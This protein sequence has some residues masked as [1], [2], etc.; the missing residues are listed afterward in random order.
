MTPKK[1][2]EFRIHRFDP[3]QE[4]HYLS[5]YEVP[6]R[7]GTTILDAL[8]Y[9]KDNLDGTLTFRHQCRMGQCGSCGV[10]VNGKPMLACYKQ[11][12]Q[13]ETDTL[14][15]EPL[16]NLPVIKDLAVDVDPFFQKFSEINPLLI[17]D[18]EE[19]QRPT[20]FIQ[21]PSDL[22]KYWDESICTKCSL[23]YA[24]CPAAI[25]LR[26]LGP[27]TLTN[28]YRFM[29]D[30]RDEGAKERIEDASE[31]I[32][33]C[34]SCDS[35]T[36]SCPKEIDCALALDE[37]RSLI[38]EDGML[39]P[40][41][42][43]EVLTSTFK[44][45]NPVRMPPGKR[46]DWGQ[47]LEIKQLPQVGE[48]DILYFVGCLPSYDERNQQIARSMAQIFRRLDEE[49][50]T[51][52]TEEWCCGDHI[53]R[54]GEK[55]L[56]EELA[57]H[58]LSVFREY[59]FHRLVTLSPHCYHT[60]K[61]DRPYTD[62][63]MEVQHYTQFLVEA[64]QKGSIESAKAIEK[65]VTYHDP[66]FLGKRSEIYEQPR[67]ILRW[68][69]GLELVEMGR[70]RENSFCCGGGA[71][72]V[73]TEE[74]TPQD[75]PAVDRAEEALNLGVDIIATACPFCITTLEDAVKVLDAEY[76]IMVRDL[77]ELLCEAI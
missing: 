9:I 53:L 4:K 43:K 70:S 30:T 16:P 51:L 45:H 50:A 13:L 25:D 69:P 17:K 59:N 35:C 38:V 36:L 58:N 68:I 29:V 41:T 37:E 19:L 26:F 11:V 71:G 2:V 6:V 31:T 56:F 77:S 76:K 73:W 62:L 20:E 23:C 74:A 49:F 34:T 15:V 72:R 55:G 27:A 54:L 39:V 8:R 75:R 52:G 22:K 66:C 40:K 1:I 14:E 32:Y 60:F 21:P 24:S 48:T 61:N 33:L 44:Y 57:E 67:Q 42:V 63:K 7:T 46:T 28:N 65:K 3:Q 64:L 12:L 5:T 18:R 10:Q 47:G